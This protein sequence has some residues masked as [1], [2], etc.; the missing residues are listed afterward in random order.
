M[1]IPSPPSSQCI[2]GCVSGHFQGRAFHTFTVSVQTITNFQWWLETE[3]FDRRY[4]S[5]LGV[6]SRVSSCMSR[7]IAQPR[8]ESP[9]MRKTIYLPHSVDS[10]RAH[11]ARNHSFLV[12]MPWCDWLLFSKDTLLGRLW[13]WICHLYAREVDRWIYRRSHLIKKNSCR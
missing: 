13:E 1:E 2:L 11:K 4:L 10:F 9:L 3:F 8:K 6:G 12:C 5:V 7:E